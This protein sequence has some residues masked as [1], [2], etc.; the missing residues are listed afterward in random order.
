LIRGHFVRAPVVAPPLPRARSSFRIP[1]RPQAQ[2]TLASAACGTIRKIYQLRSGWGAGGDEQEGL[3]GW[4]Q[5]V[6]AGP[7]PSPACVRPEPVPVQ[8]RARAG[9]PLSFEYSRP[10][11]GRGWGWNGGS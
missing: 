6:C 3:T 7:G 9:P 10:T 8:A 2:T 11:C 4:P 1:S 5:P